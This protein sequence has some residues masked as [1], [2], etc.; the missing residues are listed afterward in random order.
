MIFV[1]TTILITLLLIAA[2]RLFHLG[3][4][5]RA[6]LTTIY[7]AWTVVDAILSA[8]QN[9]GHGLGAFTFSFL[10]SLIPLVLW[11]WISSWMQKPT[12]LDTVIA[13]TG[14][15]VHAITYEEMVAAVAEK[16][17]ASKNAPLQS[18]Q[19]ES[20]PNPALNYIK[21]LPQDRVAETLLAAFTQLCAT[22]VKESKSSAKTLGVDD[23][24]FAECVL[25]LLLLGGF[26]K[27]FEFARD[28][29]L[30]S[31]YID[32]IVFNVTNSNP[33][34]IP[35]D[36]EFEIGGTERYRGI[37]KYAL[38]KD[39]YK[40]AFPEAWLFGKEY[41][42]LKSGNA[43]DFAYVASVGPVVTTIMKTGALIFERTLKHG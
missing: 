33:S 42:M 8:N 34:E 3:K 18:L 26:D 23:P 20:K 22:L 30:A 14:E 32:A 12:R 2:E 24:Q 4:R 1:G 16:R 28:K 21:A 31:A 11:Q 6:I 39:H 36:L 40:L 10:D 43:N 35:D 13:E 5:G 17:T 37:A 9:P 29:A 27:V 19:S 25:D 7:L 15:P 38:A 41:S